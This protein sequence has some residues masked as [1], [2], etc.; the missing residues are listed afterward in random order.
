MSDL[1]QPILSLL[2]HVDHGKT[3][4]LDRIAGSVRA[5][6]EAGGITQ[7]IG[8][9]EVPR[10]TVLELCRGILRTD[11]FVVPG[12]LIIDTPGHR[13]F[14]TMRRRGGALAD[15]AIL[16]IDCKDGVMPQT[17]E[18]IQIL[19][20]EKTPFAVALTKID[21]LPGWRKP[22]GPV[23]LAEHLNR[24]G[25]EF[26]K[27]VDE[28]LYSVAESL[29]EFG[30]SA[31]RFDRVS[32]FTRNVGIVPV[33]ARSGV[34]VPELLAL[35][36]GLSQRFLKAELVAEPG[37]A[38]A[39]VLERSEQRG[40]G[41]VASIILYR[42]S[43]KVGDEVVVTGR[44]QPFTAKIR[45]LYR[46]RA[47]AKGKEN[48][49]ARLQPVSSVS[50]AAGVYLAAPSIENALPGG[51]IKSVG[52]ESE[53]AE[54]IEE[55]TRE[56]ASTVPLAEDGVQVCA[57]TL[58]GLEALAFECA[59]ANVPIHAAEVGPVHRAIVLRTMTMHDPLHRA[60]LA[61]NVPVLPDALPETMAEP[62]RV[63]RGEVMYRLLEE[64]AAW[65]SERTAE[66]ERQ[67]RIDLIHP[68]KFQFLP[69]FVFRSSKPAI[70]GIKVL[71]GQLRPGVRIMR[72]D[73]TEVG[74]LRSLQRENESVKE[75]AEGDELAASL[76]GAVVGRT[77]QEGDT[78]YVALPEAAA[79]LLRG[80]S[81]S[82]SERTVLEEV[83]RIRRAT[84]GP[85]WGQ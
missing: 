38:E 35:L 74:L 76:D 29:V 41:P 4:L 64:Y 23:G 46:P 83:T 61:F 17:R 82:D 31:D 63:F 8:A 68:A 18:S 44:A 75:A 6:H 27:A 11:Q 28:R 67:R 2:G 47:K 30:L 49:A 37:A 70:F 3:T 62:V 53:R 24:C 13:S 26:V 59:Q 45:G 22:A 58:G 40:V 33:S 73:G 39:T 60:V 55:L 36:V 21:L 12:L 20:H 42:G 71:A 9:I 50:A 72:S 69:G 79:R 78:L 51:V 57:D 52:S 81:L 5:L 84:Q 80:K 10:E 19:K 48:A 65:K 15:L 16:V 34:G 25:P 1:R 7:H 56:V 14:E 77:I 54:A 66:L 43:L 32:D 85:F